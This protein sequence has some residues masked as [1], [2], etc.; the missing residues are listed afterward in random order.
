MTPLRPV[1][2]PDGMGPRSLSE[3]RPGQRA[4]VVRIA[5]SD[6]ARVVKLS[7]LGVM[8]G[9]TVTFVQRH[10][11]V[12]LRVAE[13]SMALDEDVAADILVELAE[14]DSGR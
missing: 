4:T 13:T 3:L 2:R 10:P 11:A 5:S 14:V 8:P 1:S 12:V 7:S 9:A 6:P